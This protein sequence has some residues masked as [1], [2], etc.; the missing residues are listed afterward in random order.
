MKYPNSSLSFVNLT[1]GLLLGDFLNTQY[2]LYTKYDAN[3]LGKKIPVIHLKKFT[4]ICNF[5][6]FNKSFGVYTRASGTYATVLIVQKD[7][8]LVKLLLPSQKQYVISGNCLATLGRNSNLNKKYQV[9][10][11]AKLGRRG[12]FR[13]HVRG[14]AMNPVDHPHGGRT[15]T[16][17]PEVSL[18]GWVAKASH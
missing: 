5:S 18:W 11:S 13:P 15:K 1:H 4:I 9:L 3:L 10:G 12:G 14:V 8:N 17:K 2:Y 16:N 6:I 7:Y